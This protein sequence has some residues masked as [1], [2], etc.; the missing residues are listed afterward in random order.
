MWVCVCMDK[1]DEYIINIYKYLKKYYYILS[2]VSIS[3]LSVEVRSGAIINQAG[4]AQ[5]TVLDQEHGQ[6]K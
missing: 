4:D 2:F 3:Y 5:I 6:K 1:S